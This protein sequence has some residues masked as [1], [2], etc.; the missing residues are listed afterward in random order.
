M[1]QESSVQLVDFWAKLAFYSLGFALTL[2][3]GACGGGGGGSTNPP[4][5]P[6]RWPGT[7]I[8]P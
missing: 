8:L 1:K 7:G 3:L 2:G 4:T 5:H 6:V